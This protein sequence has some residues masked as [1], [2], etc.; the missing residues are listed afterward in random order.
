MITHFNK[1]DD[2]SSWAHLINRTQ[3]PYEKIVQFFDDFIRLSAS[4]NLPE[5]ILILIFIDN[6]LE[7]MKLHI[8]LLLKQTHSLNDIFALAKQY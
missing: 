7:P 4:F 3:K 1:E 8:K 2:Y 6:L 5:N